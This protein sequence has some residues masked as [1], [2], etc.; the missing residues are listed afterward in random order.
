M[1]TTFIVTYM[2]TGILLGGVYPD[3]SISCL[4][5]LVY[6]LVYLLIETSINVDGLLQ[7]VTHLK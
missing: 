4:L 5:P 1:L 7:F 3:L 6:S 2:M